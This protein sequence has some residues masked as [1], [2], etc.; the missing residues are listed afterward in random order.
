MQERNCQRRQRKREKDHPFCV[1]EESLSW[2]K[3]TAAKVCRLIGVPR[4]QAPSNRL[5]GSLPFGARTS[6]EKK[7]ERRWA[8]HHQ[9]Q[10]FLERAQLCPQIGVLGLHRIELVQQRDPLSL[11]RRPHRLDLF[12][13]LAKRLLAF[14][15]LTLQLLADHFGSRRCLLRESERLGAQSIVCLR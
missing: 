6:R 5:A 15:Q 3:E 10:S 7:K 13:S 11:L 4:H 2:S 14:V 12:A 1:G 8:D 9:K